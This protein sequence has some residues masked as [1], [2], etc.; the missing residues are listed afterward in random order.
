M[1]MSF[2]TRFLVAAI[3]PS[4]GVAAVFTGANLIPALE[5][6]H[7]PLEADREARNTVDGKGGAK[8]EFLS[9][10]RVRVS[11]AVEAAGAGAAGTAP[12]YDPIVEACGW[13]KTVN[14]GVSVV[15]TPVTAPSAWKRATLVGGFGGAQAAPGAAD[16]Q[17][18]EVLDAMGSLGFQANE[19]QLPRFSFDMTGIYDDPVARSTVAAASPLDLGP[20][21]NAAFRE[22]VQV[23]FADTQFSFAGQALRLREFSFQD[24]APIILADRPNEFSTRRG[25]RRITGRMVVTAPSLATFDY[26]RQAALGTVQALSLTHRTVAGEIVQIT[27]P[28]VQ[29]FFTEHGDD[30]DEVTA[31]FDLNFTPVAGDDEI[32]VTVR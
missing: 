30:Q 19:N 8:P 7:R 25:L 26:I 9:R 28:A 5:L 31:T 15:Y 16:D 6:N 10:R 18:Q 13:T 22:T 1:P 20:L 3:Q 32:T 11:G 24:G 21:A 29:G 17:I 23:S 27:A 2:Q 14:A 4:A 12:F